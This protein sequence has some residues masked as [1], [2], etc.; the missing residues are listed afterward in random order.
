MGG[1]FEGWIKQEQPSSA[2]EDGRMVYAEVIQPEGPN[3]DG[4]VLQ[5]MSTNM[6]EN[7]KTKI[8]NGYF[9]FRYKLHS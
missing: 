5:S 3:R 6:R 8:I 4:I 7:N 2:A 1:A 9:A